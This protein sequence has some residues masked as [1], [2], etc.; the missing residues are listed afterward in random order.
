MA[1]ACVGL[2]AAAGEQEIFDTALVGMPDR[3][4]TQDFVARLGV[5]QRP[6]AAHLMQQVAMAK[7]H[8]FRF[9]G[10]ARGIE[11]GGQSFFAAAGHRRQRCG[12]ALGHKALPAKARQHARTSSSG[13]FPLQQHHEPQAL[14]GLAIQLKPG[15]QGC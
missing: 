6:Q 11:Q 14:A 5:D 1:Q 15:Q 13:G 7:G 9:A 2:A 12:G 3:Q 10:G 8:P 4:H